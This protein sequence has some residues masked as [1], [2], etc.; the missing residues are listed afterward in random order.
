[1]RLAAD[2][3]RHYGPT[4]AVFAMANEKWAGIDVQWREAHREAFQA[5][6]IL[7]LEEE[8]AA[9]DDTVKATSPAKQRSRH[10]S[11]TTPPSPFVFQALAETPSTSL[12]A[13]ED[14]YA[15][16]ILP[17]S[18]DG[19]CN[20][21]MRPGESAKFPAVAEMVGP[22]VQYAAKVPM[23][24]SNGR[25]LP[26]GVGSFD[27]ERSYFSEKRGRR[28]KR[29]RGCIPLPSTPSFSGAREV[30]VGA[31]RWRSSSAAEVPIA[32]KAGLSEKG[33]W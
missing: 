17:S 15:S 20:R 32:K 16:F 28:E 7:T 18:D 12:P 29:G 9:R 27:E 13:P 10:G 19:L 21:N 4:S 6:A 23:V 24:T 26:G 11:T 14:A 3:A 31:F 33:G 5:V 8:A 30:I 1:M 2:I 22:M 25:K